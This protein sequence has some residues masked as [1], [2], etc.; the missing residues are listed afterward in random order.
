MFV[1]HKEAVEITEA[2]AKMSEAIREG[3]K[4][5]PKCTGGFFMLVRTLRHPI[6][7]ELGSCALG[8]AGEYAFG[9][10]KGGADWFIEVPR[11]FGV[12]SHITSM[13]WQMNDQGESREEVADWLE[14]QGY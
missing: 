4:L 1:E 5:R 13:A 2:P 8:A 12:P 11:F 9:H 3:A 6:R 14:A 7:G 10:T